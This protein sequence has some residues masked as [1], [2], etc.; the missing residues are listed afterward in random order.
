MSLAYDDALFRAQLPEFKDATKYPPALIETFW[1]VATLYVSSSGCPCNILTG[2]Q[3]AYAVN[4][5]AAQLMVLSQQQ[6]NAAQGPGTE[7]GGFVT[8]ATIGEISVSNMPPPAAD[9]WTWWMA[10]TPY[11]QALAGLLRMLSRGGLHVGG[12]PEGDA[13]RR[14]GGIFG[15]RGRIC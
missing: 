14:V 11:G 6:S 13:F 12:L 5:M 15:S 10:K 1:D 2:K 7:Q 9:M 3:L 8:S 4:L